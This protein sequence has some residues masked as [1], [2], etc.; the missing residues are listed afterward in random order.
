MNSFKIGNNNGQYV[1]GNYPLIDLKECDSVY[2]LDK[3]KSYGGDIKKVYQSTST[4]KAFEC[5]DHVIYLESYDTDGLYVAVA[6]KNDN[7]NILSAFRANI[8]YVNGNS[9]IGKDRIRCTI[10]DLF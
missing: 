1:S 9:C 2:V 7:L 8:I 3:S 6:D 5:E 4:F 10:K